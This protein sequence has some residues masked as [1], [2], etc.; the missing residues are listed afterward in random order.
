MQLVFYPREGHGL[1]DYYHQLDKMQREYEWITR[2]T[3]GGQKQNAL[4]P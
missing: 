1:S 4:V 3:M 2:Y